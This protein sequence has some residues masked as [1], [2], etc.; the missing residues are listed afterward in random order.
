VIAGLVHGHDGTGRTD[1]G[2][3]ASQQEPI[4]TEDT[5]TPRPDEAPTFQ[6]D[7]VQADRAREQGLGLGEREL[8]AQRDPGGVRTADEEPELETGASARPDEETLDEDLGVLGAAEE[9]EDR[10]AP[11][12]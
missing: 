3:Q 12:A 8:E 5:N 6:T 7:T 11:Q 2:S 4:M 1:G 9:D 10:T